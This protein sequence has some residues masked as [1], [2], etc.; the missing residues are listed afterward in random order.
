MAKSGGVWRTALG[1]FLIV[2]VDVLWVGSS[3]FVKYVIFGDVLNISSGNVSEDGYD[4][5]YYLTYLC[6]GLFVVYLP[7][8]GARDLILKATSAARQRKVGPPVLE[9]ARSATSLLQAPVASDGAKH[10][11]EGTTATPQPA[12]GILRHTI[13]W[14]LIVCPF[15]FAANCT[16]NVSQGLTSVTSN[17]IISST[18]GTRNCGSR[19]CRFLLI[20]TDTSVALF[21]LRISLCFWL[22]CHC[23]MHADRAFHIC[24]ELLLHQREF[25]TG[26]AG[27][28][29]PQ[30]WWRM[31][32][33]F[34]GQRRGDRELGYV[35]EGAI[36][37]LW[38]THTPELDKHRLWTCAKS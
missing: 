19:C 4:I 1:V 15:W 37:V 29:F 35:A 6:N 31:Y 18:S 3:F 7:I 5:P 26:E 10:E 28:D 20:I 11:P 17:S 33:G 24:S 22:G 2:V 36:D 38:T 14:A 9:E 12:G 21:H 25:Y 16:Y 32:C 27:G 23:C 13:K 34:E 30:Y 8:V